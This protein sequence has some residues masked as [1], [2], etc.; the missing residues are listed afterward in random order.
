MPACLGGRSRITARLILRSM[1]AASRGSIAQQSAGFYSV[2]RLR[3]A[4]V[5]GNNYDL[6]MGKGILS[7]DVTY[8]IYA[9]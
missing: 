5:N 6:S 9:P 3:G 4:A 1:G 7:A 2:Y 8:T